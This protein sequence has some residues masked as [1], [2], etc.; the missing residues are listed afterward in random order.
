MQATWTKS[1]NEIIPILH[2]QLQA[3]MLTPIHEIVEFMRI[4]MYK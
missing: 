1:F 2:E 4:E 3:I